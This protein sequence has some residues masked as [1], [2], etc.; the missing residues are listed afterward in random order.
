MALESELLGAHALGVR[1]ILALTAEWIACGIAVAA[2]ATGHTRGQ[3]GPPARWG[4]WA[5][6]TG[7]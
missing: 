2:V 5:G 3:N 1:N 7:P 6:S 4:V